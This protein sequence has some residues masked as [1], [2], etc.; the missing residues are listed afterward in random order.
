MLPWLHGHSSTGN[1]MSTDSLPI[2][3]SSRSIDLSALTNHYAFYIFARLMSSCEKNFMS[4]SSKRRQKPVSLLKTFM[5]LNYTYI[6]GV[7]VLL[8]TH[9]YMLLICNSPGSGITVVN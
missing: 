6:G 1:F 7:C 4:D 8:Y 3:P 5:F 9:V 2:L